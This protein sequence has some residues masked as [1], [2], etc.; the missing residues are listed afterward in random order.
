MQ[1]QETVLAGAKM[2]SEQAREENA[3]TLG[4][5]AFLWGY[6]LRF[7]GTL[8]PGSLK[9]GGTYLNDFHKFTDLKTAKDRFIVTPNNVTIDSYCNFDVTNEPLVL[10]V[11]KLSAPR[12]YIVQIGDSFDEVIHNVGGI[13]GE[14][15]GVYLITGPDFSG[16]IPGE[17]IQDPA[18]QARRHIELAPGTCRAIQ[19]DYAL[20][21]T[22]DSD[23][24]W[25]IPVTR[26][27]AHAI[28]MT[29]S[30]TWQHTGHAYRPTPSPKIAG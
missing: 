7:Y 8:I 14:Q 5:Q 16:R 6:P 9:A 13:K 2:S 30:S 10:F 26:R 25:L 28:D 19:S 17:M 27:A 3:Y 24:R 23:P 12:W 1:A 4:V 18:R 21:W 29:Q 15:P 20:L 22:R 11:P